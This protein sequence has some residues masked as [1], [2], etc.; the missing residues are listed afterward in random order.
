[1][2]DVEFPEGAP[3]SEE[4]LLERANRLAGRS[5]GELA[6]AVEMEVP[7]DLTR[8]KGWVGRLIERC[9]GADAGNKPVPDFTS[10][11]V[12]LKTLPVDASGKPFES[13]YVSKVPL[14]GVEELTWD[15]STVRKK[16]HRVLWVPIHSESDVPLGRR[17]VGQALL[18]S[19]TDDE[20]DALRTDWEDHIDTIRRGFVENI[21]AEDGDVLQIRPKAADASARTEGVD[22][23]GG[24]ILTKP[25]G[26]YLRTLFTEYLLK[27]HFW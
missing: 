7:A 15:E 10:I 16:L 23:N 11:D 14:T 13:T 9:L 18:W 20:E 21:W 25:R 8:D 2:D 5:L 3:G 1:M 6:R 22:P 12:E 4:E 24:S 19:A 27:K 17:M 26:F